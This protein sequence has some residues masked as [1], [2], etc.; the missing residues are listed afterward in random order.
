M[1][2]KKANTVRLVYK[3]VLS[4]L[5][6][7][8]AA[9]FIMQVCRIYFG[10]GSYT[11]A[12]VISYLKQIAVP[13]WLWIAVIFIGFVLWEVLP[14]EGKQKYG[15][16]VRYSLYRLKKKLPVKAEGDLLQDAAAV[17]KYDKILKI[18]WAICAAACVIFAAAGL[19]YLLNFDNF[20]AQ[21]LIP[22]M[23]NA[24]INV[25]P[26]VICAFAL[27]IGAS[28]YSGYSAKKQL[29]HLKRL[30]ALGK[31]ESP[32]Y[33]KVERVYYKAVAA[34]QSD[35]FTWTMRAIIFVIGVILVILGVSNGGA[36]DV[37]GKAIN[38]C[39]ECIGLG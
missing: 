10:V 14:P 28:I 19:T 21:N 29:P 24:V 8:V 32:E 3:I 1:T 37:L 12:L 33:N 30:A 31:A 15:Q 35:A 17:A 18:I 5:T 9:L 4:V 25:F 2:E 39:T 6:A 27:C 20:P 23:V 34:V 38:I 16:D 26:F 22:E 36:G 13:F 7:V 11:R